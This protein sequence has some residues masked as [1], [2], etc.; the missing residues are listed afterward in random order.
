M[1]FLLYLFAYRTLGIKSTE[2]KASVSRPPPDHKDS[3]NELTASTNLPFYSFFL[4][5]CSLNQTEGLPSL[6]KKKI[7]IYREIATITS[8]PSE[9]QIARGKMIRRHVSD[10]VLP[11]I[12]E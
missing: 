8:G 11:N 5:K 1:S 12:N 2:F 4:F 6:H 7:K 10:F 3:S 9:T